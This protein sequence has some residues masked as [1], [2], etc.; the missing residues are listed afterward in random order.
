MAVTSLVRDWWYLYR[1][2]Y[3][4]EVPSG[5]FGR[6]PVYA[7]NPDHVVALESAHIAAGYVPQSGGYIGSRRRCPTGISGKTCQQSGKDCSLHNYDLAWDVEYNYNPHFHR[8]LTESTLWALYREGK[9]KYNSD[10]VAS[11]LTVKNTH[12]EQLFRWLGY[13]IGDTMHWQIN[14]P[15][16]RQE[17]DWSTVGD[18]TTP[19][20]AAAGGENNMY[21]PLGYSD[22]FRSNP[23][24]KEDVLWLQKALNRAGLDAGVE[25][26]AYGRDTSAAVLRL[27]LG[28][29]GRTFGAAEYDV[30]LSRAY[31][32]EVSDVVPAHIHVVPKRTVVIDKSST[33][34][35]V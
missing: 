11:I 2:R 5:F 9:T 1:C 12:G 6:T 4:K 30:L 13:A 17:V 15:P 22:G 18:R 33:G 19:I 32:S 14:V 20:A 16:S 35:A 25:D 7:Q 29:D 21:L 3:G 28:G 10:I 24:R 8:R 34:G 31:S 27:G 26:G 23:R